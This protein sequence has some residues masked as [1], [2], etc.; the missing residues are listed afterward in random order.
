MR[1]PL[2]KI[3]IENPDL[4]PTET[5]ALLHQA[6]MPEM[7][8]AAIDFDA[9][10]KALDQYE[11]LLSDQIRALQNKDKPESAEDML[12]VH[13]ENWFEYLKS[14]HAN[15]AS[16]F[17]EIKNIE[18]DFP[19]QTRLAEMVAE[20]IRTDYPRFHQEYLQHQQWLKANTESLARQEQ[21]QLQGEPE[22]TCSQ[23]GHAR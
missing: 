23:D 11:E 3:L 9:F 18:C 5:Y 4:N 14:E 22:Q 8:E 12:K 17:G 10:S 13:V 21:Q 1:D 16:M 20:K 7:T 2:H 6:L 19:D 15:L